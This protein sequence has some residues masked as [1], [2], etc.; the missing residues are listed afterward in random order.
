MLELAGIAR[1]K[2]FFCH[3]VLATRE[4]QRAESHDKIGLPVGVIA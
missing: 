3:H 2:K 4:D 1:N